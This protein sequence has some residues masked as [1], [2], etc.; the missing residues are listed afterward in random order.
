MTFD[1]YGGE[2]P[3]VG[4][5]LLGQRARHVV[6]GLRP[7][8]S[9]L[10]HDRWSLEVRKMATDEPIPEGAPVWETGTCPPGYCPACTATEA[11][12]T[13]PA[14]VVHRCAAGG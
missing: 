3:T 9:K 7:I 10:W 6:T 2:V 12:L 1:V 13:I 8:D 11:G 14:F 5:V 4:L